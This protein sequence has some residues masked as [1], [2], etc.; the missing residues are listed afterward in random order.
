LKKYYLTI[1]IACLWQYLLYAQGDI[2]TKKSP[3]TISRIIING[4]KKT[5]SYIILREL[6]FKEKDT[7]S[8]PDLVSKFDIARQ[9]LYNTRLFNDIVGPLKVFMATRW[10]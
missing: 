6:P 2:A 10:R 4:N 5:K 1:T 7:V 8:L 9:Q 3:F